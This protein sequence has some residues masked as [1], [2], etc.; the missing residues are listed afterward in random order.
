VT[1]QQIVQAGGVSDPAARIP[2]DEAIKEFETKPYTYR[3]PPE[4]EPRG[5]LPPPKKTQV[6]A[7]ENAR[8]VVGEVDAGMVS[9]PEAVMMPAPEIYSEQQSIG[10]ALNDNIPFGNDY[11]LTTMTSEAMGDV[12]DGEVDAGMSFAPEA[13]M[14]TPS[15]TVLARQSAGDALDDKLFLRDDYALTAITSEA[16]GH[17][18]DITHPSFQAEPTP[19]VKQNLLT[20]AMQEMVQPQSQVEDDYTM[21]EGEDIPAGET[22]MGLFP[23]GNPESMQHIDRKDNSDDI[24]SDDGFVV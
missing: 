8:R 3:L 14:M 16:I 22:D 15:E 9:A 4:G 6:H 24:N 21:T 20:P 7:S 12:V 5:D 23:A 18:S 17:E 2:S 11:D 1:S 19:L 10:G 13:I